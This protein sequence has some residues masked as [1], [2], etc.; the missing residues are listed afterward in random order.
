LELV[1]PPELF[2][3][4]AR[5]LIASGAEG[6]E[7]LGLLLDEAFYDGRALALFRQLDRTRLRDAWGE[8]ANLFGPL[9]PAEQLVAELARD[10]ANLPRHQPRRYYSARRRPQA[11]PP[12]MS[13]ERTKG[14]FARE[15]VGLADVGYFDDAFGSSCVDA[16]EDPDGQGQRRLS[17]LLD[18][19]L[20]MWPLRR[21]GERTRI[22]DD[23][24]EE[25]F[26][27]VVEVLHDLVA[28]PRARRWHDYGEEWDYSDFSRAPGRAVYRW[29]IND[30]FDRSVMP[31]R[32]AESGPDQGQLVAAAGDDR[33]LLVQRALATPQS[34]DRDEV[35]HAVALFRGRH[36]NRQDKRS[37]IAALARILEARR[38]LLKQELREDEGALFM[39]ANRFDIRHR[40]GKQHE[41]YAEAYLD[42]VFW[43]YLA[44]V[45]LSDQLLQRQADAG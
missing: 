22:E 28:R 11:G 39:I 37:A 24:S 27:D 31:L 16:H 26:Y 34:G 14:A 17:D 36:A 38:A 30:L 44:T 9:P 45:E 42:W 20:P 5:S 6:E 23:W 8:R 1:W 15:V 32:L 33:D 2:A 7:T 13:L 3:A 10:A 19:D 29:R 4:E 40:D 35:S 41:D 21:A 25:Q 12:P 18:T 43:W